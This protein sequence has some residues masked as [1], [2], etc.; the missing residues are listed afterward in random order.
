MYFFTFII[1]GQ[2]SIK[3]L[4]TDSSMITVISLAFKKSVGAIQLF[5]FL[6]ISGQWDQDKQ[7]NAT[8]KNCKLSHWAVEQTI[9]ITVHHKMK[10]IPV[11]CYKP[12]Q[13]YTHLSGYKAWNTF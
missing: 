12:L 8:K 13:E 2:I 11:F 7:A 9:L 3:A 4:L 10:M 1:L 5:V 6:L